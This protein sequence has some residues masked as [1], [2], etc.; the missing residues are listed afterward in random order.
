MKASLTEETPDPRRELLADAARTAG[1]IWARWWF[2]KLHRQGRPVVGGWPGTMSESRCRTRLHVEA[3]LSLRALP[4]V[5]HGEL[6]EA[7][8]LTYSC[9]KALW[10]GYQVRDD[11]IA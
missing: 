4:P 9:A 11:D 3:L 2:E 10:L 6:T 8:R 7:T 5:T 1:K